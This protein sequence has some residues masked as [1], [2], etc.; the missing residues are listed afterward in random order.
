MEVMS[1]EYAGAL[2]A[3]LSVSHVQW[4]LLTDS[5][6][7]C[8]CLEALRPLLALC[9]LMQGHALFDQQIAKKSRALRHL[10]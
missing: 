1:F 4:L 9:S 3:M 5:L 10:P 8:Y 6:M 7:Q 2:R